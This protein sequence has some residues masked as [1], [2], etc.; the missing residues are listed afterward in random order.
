MWGKPPF[1]IADNCRTE[2][3][4]SPSDQK[5]KALSF[6][7]MPPRPRIRVDWNLQGRYGVTGQEGRC[8]HENKPWVATA[9]F[10]D[11]G[12]LVLRSDEEKK[13]RNSLCSGRPFPCCISVRSAGTR[14]FSRIASSQ[15]RGPGQT[16]LRTPCV[17][18]SVASASQ[19]AADAAWKGANC[20]GVRRSFSFTG[21]WR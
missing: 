15:H 18:A 14:K 19:G 16:S 21:H 3:Q 4:E 9:A 2:L 5:R 7:T 20:L 13:C 17:G 11:C 1:F 8:V 6:C 12:Q 10:E